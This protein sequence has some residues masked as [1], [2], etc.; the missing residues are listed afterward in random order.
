MTTPEA[1][2]D[3]KRVGD[4]YDALHDEVFPRLGAIDTKLTTLE[5]GMQ[6]ILIQGCPQRADDLRRTHSLELS[7]GKIFDKIDG[8]G[9]TL[10]EFRVDVTK[11]IGG[12]KTDITG[13]GSGIRIWILTAAL[14]VAV[15][16]LVY[17][18]KDYAR[19]IETHVGKAA[20][21]SPSTPKK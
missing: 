6:T 4:V 19:D 9:A 18:A 15:G 16:L 20:I 10:S 14:S 5:H 11:E 1:Q 7:I 12:I 8:F 21:I 13:K 2:A 3:R 17:F